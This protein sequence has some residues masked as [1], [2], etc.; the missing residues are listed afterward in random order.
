M[1][2]DEFKLNTTNVLHI[3]HNGCFTWI[4]L[5][6]AFEMVTQQDYY[7]LVDVPV[8]L[9]ETHLVVL[10]PGEEVRSTVTK[11][12]KVSQHALMQ[13]IPFALEDQLVGDINQLYFAVGDRDENDNLLVSVIERAKFESYLK[14]LKEHNF[15]P[16]IVLPDY[17]TLPWEEDRWTVY[18]NGQNAL[19]RTD[20]QYGFAVEIKNLSLL[21]D[22]TIEKAIKKPNSIWVYDQF[23]HRNM[24]KHFLIKNKIPI[25]KNRNPIK[26]PFDKIIAHPPINLLQKK[27][28]PKNKFSKLR[29]YW[30]L[31]AIIF[32]IWLVALFGS[33][34][35]EWA[36]FH[37]KLL[38]VNNEVSKLYHSILP[39]Q[40][41]VVEPRY[42]IQQELQ[43]LRKSSGNKNFMI[44]ISK[45]A[46]V[47]QRYTALQLNSLSYQN[48]EITLQLKTT[49]LSRLESLSSELKKQH[50]TVKQN[51]VATNNK[52]IVAKIIVSGGGE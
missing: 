6:E 32:T 25:E 27:Y 39:N 4:Q 45:V 15:Y 47:L 30:K 9:K 38:G 20:Y 34:I 16:D 40:K 51:K 2:G 24:N 37:N 22:L 50:L 41:K 43:R 36:F 21:L 29:R 26:W 14:R 44:L 31:A 49:Q 18:I 12:P 48:S 17:L 52:S 13:A 8:M 35:A 3:H 1:A 19:V 33:Q 10:L 5:N 28:Q 46:P 23:E 7:N 11:I 42:Y